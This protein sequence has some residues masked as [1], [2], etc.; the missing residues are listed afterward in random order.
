MSYTPD[1]KWRQQLAFT[2]LYKS[3]VPTYQPQSINTRADSEFKLDP[4]INTPCFTL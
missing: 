1:P 3:S 4:I 2:P